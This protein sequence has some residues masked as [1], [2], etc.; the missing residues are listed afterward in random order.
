MGM[1]CVS[2]R[3]MY[4]TATSISVIFQTDGTARAPRHFILPY[5][6]GD[7]K[8]ITA[9]ESYDLDGFFSLIALLVCFFYATI[10]T[11]LLALWTTYQF[12]V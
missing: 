10:S 2:V 12:L 9:E 8:G 1:I 7:C 4:T 6:E 5:I 11:M 3:G